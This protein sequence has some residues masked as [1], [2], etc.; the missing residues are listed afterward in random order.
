MKKVAPIVILRH[1]QADRSYPSV[2]CTAVGDVS[3]SREQ[4]HSL[5]SI[6]ANLAD[7]TELLDAGLSASADLAG[8]ISYARAGW[9][10]VADQSELLK[11]AFVQ[12]GETTR[13][14]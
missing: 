6:T 3:A 7:G 1:K 2:T 12:L 13:I 11:V 14:D 4:A 8:I 5:W 9:L 10:D